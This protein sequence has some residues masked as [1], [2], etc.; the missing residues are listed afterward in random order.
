[1]RK[2]KMKVSERK[3]APLKSGVRFMLSGTPPGGKRVREYF[4]TRTAAEKRKIELEA[5]ITRAGFRS[6]NLSPDERRE[7]A[8]LKASL[9]P[10]DKSLADAVAFYREHLERLR[11]ESS[12]TV[13]S[14]LDK[15]I[16]AKASAGLSN[17]TKVTSARSAKPLP[18]SLGNVRVPALHGRKCAAGWLL[19]LCRRLQRT[20]SN[21][22]WARCFPL[23]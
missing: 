21:E 15:A 23:L 18:K 19:C 6:I 3:C 20:T 17:A 8:D 13:R 9:A 1:M 22:T 14:A 10:F 12:V 7:F 16:D 4:P 2:L 5:D 11:N